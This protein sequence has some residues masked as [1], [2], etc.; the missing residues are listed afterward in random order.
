MATDSGD[1]GQG[2]SGW[3]NKTNLNT[4]FLIK[5]SNFS[6]REHQLRT[7][8]KNDIFDPLPHVPFCPF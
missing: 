4:T 5:E 6:F 2:G 1:D 7:Y 3:K 8:P